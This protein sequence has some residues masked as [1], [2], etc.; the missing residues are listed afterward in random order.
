MCVQALLQ[1]GAKNK[2]VEVVAST[3]APELTPEQWFK[4]L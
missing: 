1:E 2:V 3:S 4:D